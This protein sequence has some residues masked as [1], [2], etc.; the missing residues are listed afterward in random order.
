MARFR[1]YLELVNIDECE[2]QV[3][4]Y[5]VQV[6]RARVTLVHSRS[7]LIPRMLIMMTIVMKEEP[8]MRGTDF[9]VNTPSTLLAPRTV[10]N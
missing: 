8:H 9:N 6:H 7:N 1:P 5:P 10:S 3:L 2:A 4:F